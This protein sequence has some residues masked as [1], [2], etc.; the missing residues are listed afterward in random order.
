MDIPMSYSR[1][2]DCTAVFQNP[3]PTR[4]SMALVFDDERLFGGCPGNKN[5]DDAIAYHD[6]AAYERAVSRNAVPLL[7]KLARFTPPPGRLLEIGGATG[8]F[9]KAARDFGY[10]PEGLDIS[11]ALAARVQANYGI[12]VTVDSIE[13]TNLPSQSFDAVCCFGGIECWRD[14]HQGLS[15]VFRLLRKNGFFLFNYVD[16]RSVIA[17]LRGKKYFQ[18]NPCVNYLF[19]RRTVHCL[20]GHHGFRIL[21]ERMPMAH[22]A[23][24]PLFH[25]L[26]LES[27]FQLSHRLKV[28]K[29]VFMLPNI[30]TKT[31]VAV[32]S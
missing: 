32:K 10:Q 11:A 31:V 24:G 3:L 16:C 20:L 19:N 12:Q 8:W 13:E 17:R 15:N 30:Q 29:F 25:Y 23:L 1:C 5:F 2:N 26:Q 28:D 18:Y 14:P 22:I 7:K 9:M 6:Y 21:S 27:L 4:E